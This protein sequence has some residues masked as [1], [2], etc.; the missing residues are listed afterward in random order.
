MIGNPRPIEPP[1]A[2]KGVGGERERDGYSGPLIVRRA[3]GAHR[4][5]LA[6]Q[7]HS[8]TTAT[9]PHAPRYWFAIRRSRVRVPLAPS[10]KAP[11]SV[12]FL[13]RG[14]L[15]ASQTVRDQC[16]IGGPMP[17]VLDPA[18]LERLVVVPNALREKNRFAWEAELSLERPTAP[19]ASETRRRMRS[20]PPPPGTPVDRASTSE[21][22]HGYLL[23]GSRGAPGRPLSRRL[24]DRRWG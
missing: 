6:S 18:L 24:V 4:R 16:P 10:S 7:S 1:S 9:H 23:A 20:A 2:S 5:L 17:A 11:L 15:S 3:R 8:R 21:A 12:G 22:A 13:M 19:W 14:V